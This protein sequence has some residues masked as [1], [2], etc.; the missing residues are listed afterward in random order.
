MV[1]TT[2]K[3]IA[4]GKKWKPIDVIVPGLLLTKD[5]VG[6]FIAANPSALK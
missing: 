5:T 3:A 6:A 1:S 4:A 2:L